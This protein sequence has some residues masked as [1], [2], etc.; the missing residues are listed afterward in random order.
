MRDT[1]DT[2]SHYDTIM[3]FYLISVHRQKGR[4]VNMPERTRLTILHAFDRLVERVGFSKITVSMLV[5]EAGVSRATFYRYFKDKYD[6]MNY[7]Y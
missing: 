7:N 2:L 4:F 5:K 3:L 6:V 1:I